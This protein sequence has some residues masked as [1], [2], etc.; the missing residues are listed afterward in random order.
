MARRKRQ[1][2]DDNLNGEGGFGSG[3]S[4]LKDWR[5]SGSIVVFV[6]ANSGITPRLFHLVPYMAVDEEG[7]KSI[8]FLAIVCHEDPAT[9]F[10]KAPAQYC[11]IDRA[12]DILVE[13]ESIDDDE[14]VW[15]VITGNNKKDRRITK[16]DFCGLKGGD[17][18]GSFKPRAQ[19]VIVVVNAEK[20]ES[21]LQIDVEPQSLGDALMSAIKKE[22]DSTGPEM[23]D[24]RINPYAFKF[25]Y[26][27]DASPKDKYDAHPFRRAE[28]TEEVLELLNA[29][30]VD[31]DSYIDPSN[32]SQ[33][34]KAFEA[35][36][37]VDINLD[38][39]F[40]NTLDNDEEREQSPDPDTVDDDSPM[41]NVCETCGG[42]GKVG[43]K[44]MTCP[45]CEGTGLDTSEEDNEESSSTSDDSEG[46]EKVPC[47]T[48]GGTGEIGKKKK[49]ECPDCEGTGL[50]DPEDDNDEEVKKEAERKAK[51]AKAERDRRAK[52]KK[53]ET[54]KK[55]EQKAEVTNV[56]DDY[57]SET[58][59]GG[60][61][62]MI[63][64]DATTCPYCGVEFGEDEDD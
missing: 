15:E 2:F 47:E 20:P 42:K 57:N 44:G 40:D 4:R 21:G 18:R 30:A 48:C 7:K 41:N 39:L 46:A 62:R 29:P 56:E 34:R 19:Y 32:L 1:S 52:K 64:D 49:K 55:A 3:G 59:C 17:W 14:I 36:F 35:H 10:S 54:K 13:D 31:I 16:L 25:T 63:P 6:H 22:I 12:I 58:K 28:V 61:Q 45:D 43:K 33:L 53:E 60:C 37:K 23:G 51:K 50:V 26:D 27:D 8:K 5:A 11:P 38:M 9:F 24:P